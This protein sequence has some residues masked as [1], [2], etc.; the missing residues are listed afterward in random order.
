M[1]RI[2]TEFRGDTNR[3]ATFHICQLFGRSNRP[4]IS[5]WHIRYS[6]IGASSKPPRNSAHNPRAMRPA[7]A[8]G[9]TPGPTCRVRCRHIPPTQCHRA[10]RQQAQ[11]AA[12]DRHEV[13]EAGRQLPGDGNHRRADDLVNV[14]H[15]RTPSRR[16]R[17]LPL[18]RRPDPPLPRLPPPAQAI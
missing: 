16:R 18:C 1:P 15:H 3:L 8:P 11:A 14:V 2:G 17:R 5:Y 4:L 13:R 10:V 7:E 6:P 12:W 9:N